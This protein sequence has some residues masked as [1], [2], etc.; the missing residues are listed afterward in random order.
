[1]GKTRSKNTKE[2]LTKDYY[3]GYWINRLTNIT[4]N[5]FEWK[6]LPKE[7]NPAAME[8]SIMLGGYAIFFRDKM[9]DK[10][11]AL[12][13][14]LTGVDVYGY[15]TRTKPISLSAEIY[16]PEMDI[17]ECV[18]IYANRTRTSAQLVINEYAD[19]L[20]EIDL[21]IKLNTMAMKHPV[22]IKG[23]EETKQSMEALMRQYEETYYHIIVQKGL[24]LDK[25]LEVLNFNVDATEILNLQKEKESILNEFFN[26]FG[27][28]SS[29]EKRERMITGEMNAMMQQG[30]IN[31][32][33]WLS[34]RRRACSQINEM[35]GLNLSVDYN[36]YDFETQTGADK[37]EELE[38]G[39]NNE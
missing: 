32:E 18:I 30:G 9:L 35:Y 33:V 27:I 14:A 36:S 1:M 25:D 28:V 13:G 6:N 16:F 23:T 38:K 4:C 34:A 12:G 7:I 10:Y 39:E 2:M 37:K 3:M 29:V 5:L 19:K 8:K 11:F 26:I 22:V 21:A 15:P 20:S 31:R 17:N 24:T